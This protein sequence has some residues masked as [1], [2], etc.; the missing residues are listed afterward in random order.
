MVIQALRQVVI[1]WGAAFLKGRAKKV[2]EEKKG[3]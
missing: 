1:L 3:G 2:P